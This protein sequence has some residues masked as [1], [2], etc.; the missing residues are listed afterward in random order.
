MNLLNKQGFLSLELDF[1]PNEIAQELY[2]LLLQ[3]VRWEQKNITIYEKTI[4]IPRLTAWFG[5]ATYSYS[6]IKNETQPWLPE[7]LELK[8]VIEQKTGVEFNS[9]LLNLYRNGKD[10]VGWHADNEKELG[11]NPTIASVSLGQNRSF[12]VKHKME[13]QNKLNLNLSSG[14]LVIMKEEMQHH[15]LHRLAPTSKSVEP[16]INITFRRILI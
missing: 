10:S 8:K 9:C 5:D 7:L 15:W 14:S 16:R 12:Q 1:L 4:P 11:I 6:G 2:Q 3:K 13:P